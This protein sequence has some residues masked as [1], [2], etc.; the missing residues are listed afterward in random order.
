MSIVFS[1]VDDRLVHGRVIN[2][3]IA[4]IKPTHLVIID[5]LLAEDKFMSKIF[6]ALVPIWLNIE[7]LPCS[8]AVSFLKTVDTGENRIFILAKS[9]RVFVM[10]IKSG[11][12]ISEITFADKE[13]QK[14]KLEVSTDNKHAINL[15]ISNGVM[16]YAINSPTDSKIP[17]EAYQFERTI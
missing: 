10:L 13:Y 1:R 17:M 6:R 7:I 14:N 11:I 15:L 8:S 5:D 4:E 16:L 3:W 9:P 12:K 2:D